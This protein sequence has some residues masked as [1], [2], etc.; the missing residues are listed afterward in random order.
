MNFFSKKIVNQELNKVQDEIN[1]EYEKN[2]LTDDVLDKQVAMNTIRNLLNLPD[3]KE[4][5]YKEFT[6]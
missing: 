5:I 4:K 1:K 2:G 6:Q 3:D